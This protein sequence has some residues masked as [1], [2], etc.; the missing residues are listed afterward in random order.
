MLTA[1]LL[2]CPA[3]A[4][5]PP[6]TV[7]SF[8]GGDLP[9]QY[10][11]TLTQRGAGCNGEIFQSDTGPHSQPSF[12]FA[13]CRPT[14]HIAFSTPKASVQLFAR[15]LTV[16]APSLVA[17]GHLTTGETVSVTVADPSAWRPISLSARAGAFDYVE[18]RA[19]GAD[20]GIDDL[21]IS[22][23]PQ[24]DS[25]VTSG[26]APRTEQDEATIAFGANRPDGARFECSLDGAAFA[27]CT[28]PVTLARLAAGPHT[29]RTR[30]IDVYGAVDASPAE[31]AWTVLGPPPETPANPGA[32]PIV[33]GDTATID[34]GP[35]GPAYECSVDGGAFTPCT[36]PFTAAGL[37]PG[38]HTIDV[39]AVDGDG[40]P[41]PSP[42]RYAFDVPDR[43][44]VVPANNSE[45]DLDRD[46]IPDAEE[47][48]PLGNVPP[49]AGVRTLASLVSGTVY[50]KLPATARRTH[51]V[52]ALPGFVP[53][54]GIAALPV[55]TIVDARRGK[56]LLQTAGD[57]RPESDPRRRTSRATLAEAIFRIRQARVRRPA[58][59]T[60]PLLTGLVLISAP[61]AE[62]P[63]QARAPAKGVV[64]TF[65]SRA[66]GLFRVT[67]GASFAQG[68]DATWRTS[69]RC[70]GTITRVT[71]GRVTVYDKARKRTVTVRPGARYVARARLFQARK[72]RGGS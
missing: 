13:P 44:S 49:V 5:S 17:T 10:T 28:S 29:F 56:L 35:R 23:S 31:Y 26:P 2:A 51:Q 14:L 71:R 45:T 4:Q 69:D 21:A 53:L 59:R 60:R 54:K 19:E 64:R 24:P 57:G 66:K 43:R 12:L 67:G 7:L 65:V 18:L 36:P 62:R 3:A 63:C 38:P 11:A 9:G 72:G 50:V 70:D 55:G 58:L 34:F 16:S 33:N 8:D 61:A 22:A 47:T 40:R 42:A 39:R 48:L 1:L 30:A 32:T 46:R 20:I 68:R 27:T 15:A 6:P 25:A 41:D 37:A 52:R